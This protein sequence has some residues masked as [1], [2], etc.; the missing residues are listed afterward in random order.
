MFEIN[1]RKTLRQFLRKIENSGYI[2]TANG[3]ANMY[4][5]RSQLALYLRSKGSNNKIMLSYQVIKQALQYT[6]YQRTVTRKDLEIYTKGANSALLGVLIEIFAHQCKIS[7]GRSGLLRLTIS[8]I[9]YYFAGCERSVRDLEVAAEC[10]AR[11]VLMSYAHIRNRHAWKEHVDRL[12]LKVLL[13]SGAF[14]IW[15]AKKRGREVQQIDIEEYALFIKE[16][17][18]RL[19][20]WFNLDV[21]GDPIASTKNADYLKLQG[22]QPIEVWH[23]SADVS[24]LERLVDEEPPVIAIGGS[25]GL[26]EKKRKKAFEEIFRRFPNQNFHFLGGSSKLLNEFNWFS[27][28]STGWLACRKYG[29]IFNQYGQQKAPADCTWVE[30][31]KSSCTYF[32]GLETTEGRK[33]TVHEYSYVSSKTG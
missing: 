13:D 22:L 32:A 30:A 5:G 12:G 10:G 21:V 7:R 16:N 17:Q 28:D 9:R 11:F 29:A 26:S 4:A 14:T 3:K 33:E 23:V 6:F 27:A 31:M 15:S 25:V 19:F 8:G 24:E 18:Q 20:S 2:K 1:A